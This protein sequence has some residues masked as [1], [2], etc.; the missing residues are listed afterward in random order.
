MNP[1][2]SA[3]VLSDPTLAGALAKSDSGADL[4]AA[5]QAGDVAVFDM[6]QP[7]VSATV[8]ERRSRQAPDSSEAP[9]S[10]PST[11]GGPK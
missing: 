5:L 4:R 8:A 9:A 6:S 2:P 10:T 7:V 3:R 1:S 11:P